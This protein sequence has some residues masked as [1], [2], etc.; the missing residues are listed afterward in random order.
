VSPQGKRWR[1]RLILALGP[2][3]ALLVA[4]LLGLY[5]IHRARQDR[6]DDRFRQMSIEVSRD[7]TRFLPTGA[8]TVNR[9]VVS[10]TCGRAFSSVKAQELLTCPNLARLDLSGCDPVDLDGLGRLNQLRHLRALSLAGAAVDDRALARLA[11]WPALDELILDDTRIT[12]AGLD[13]LLRQRP[14]RVVSVAGVGF[15]AGEL[16]ALR[17]AFPDVE[18]RAGDG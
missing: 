10:A 6:A 2:P 17:G 7:A 3:L 16:D 8:G 15:R 9:S 11:D 18:F 5:P 12:A 13:L 4:I 14:V 1:R